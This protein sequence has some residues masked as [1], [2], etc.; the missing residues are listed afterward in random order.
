MS[1]LVLNADPVALANRLRPL[2]LRLNRE[3][4]REG[5]ALGITGGQATL[6]WL[7][8]RTP[9]IGVNELAGRERISAAG[10]SGHVDRLQAAGLVSRIRS[11]DDRRRVGLVLTDEGQ[12]VL[13]AVRRRR[14]EWLAQRLGALAPEELEALDAAAGP[15]GKLLEGA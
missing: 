6:L 11:T 8:S 7:I 15:L 9:G 1:D 4:R 10:M 5:A 12:R 14:T 3:L 2:L 13:R